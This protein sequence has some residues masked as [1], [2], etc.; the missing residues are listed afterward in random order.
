MPA[1]EARGVIADCSYGEG[2]C[3]DQCLGRSPRSLWRPS[4]FCVETAPDTPTSPTPTSKS[5]SFPLRSCARVRPASRPPP[6]AGGPRPSARP[7]ISAAGPCA[8]R[9]SAPG[10]GPWRRGADKIALHVGEASKDGDHQP[11]G[12]GAGVVP[13][14]CQ[15]A[16]LRPRVYDALE[17]AEQV[18]KCCARGGRCALLV[19]TSPERGERGIL[20]RSRRSPRAPVA[21]AVKSWRVPPPATAEAGHRRSGLMLTLA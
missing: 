17:D 4:C 6:V 13:R 7:S 15:R 16:E 2:E 18:E 10:C 12:A 3:S 11:P 14:F 5:C 9:A 21:F 1:S 19:T 20:R 8:A